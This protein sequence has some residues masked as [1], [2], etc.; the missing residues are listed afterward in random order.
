MVPHRGVFELELWTVS[1]RGLTRIEEVGTRGDEELRVVDVLD[2]F[3]GDDGV[4]TTLGLV[5]GQLL[6]RRISGISKKSLI[7]KLYFK[8]VSSKRKL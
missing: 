2:D 4:E 5:V 8:N 3:G 1:R 6:D 7:H